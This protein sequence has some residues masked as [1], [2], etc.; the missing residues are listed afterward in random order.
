LGHRIGGNRIPWSANSFYGLRLLLGITEAGFF[1]GVTFFLAAWFPAS[2]ARGCWPGSWW[3]SLVLAGRRASL[4]MMLQMRSGS[5]G[6][7][8]GNGCFS[9]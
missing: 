6:S 4:R 2:T 9:W 8:D 3:H 1:P 5:G 7:P